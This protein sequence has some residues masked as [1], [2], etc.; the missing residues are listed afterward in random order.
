M[1]F[2][3]SLVEMLL[4]CIDCDTYSYNFDSSRSISTLTSTRIVWRKVK[5]VRE[6]RFW[7]DSNLRIQSPELKSLTTIPP[8][9]FL[10][11][12][13]IMTLKIL[14]RLIRNNINIS[15]TLSSTS[16]EQ[17]QLVMHLLMLCLTF[18]TFITVIYKR[19]I[20]CSQHKRP[21]IW[22]SVL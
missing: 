21:V 8:Q 2:K 22:S 20:T 1:V 5:I 3:G 6:C 18:V 19:F 15:T 11:C 9:I 12:K 16:V 7:R 17:Y 4:S 13:V 14:L 10:K